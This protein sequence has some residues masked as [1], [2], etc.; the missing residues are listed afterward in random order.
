MTEERFD[1][2]AELRKAYEAQTKQAYTYLMFDENPEESEAIQLRANLMKMAADD[3]EKAHQVL[4]YVLYLRMYGENAPGGNETWSVAESLVEGWLRR[5][6]PNSPL[7]DRSVDE[8]LRRM[9]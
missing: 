2:V 4:E 3:M 9:R 7:H 5:D 6:D 1:L 8:A